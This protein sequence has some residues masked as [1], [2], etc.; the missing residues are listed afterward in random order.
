MTRDLTAN[1]WTSCPGPIGPASVRLF[2][3]PYAGGG[4]SSF[5]GW[6]EHLGDGIVACPVHLPGRERRMR[7]PA[8]RRM[9]PLA[10]AVADALVSHADRPYAFF[11]HSMGAVLAYEAALEL[12]ARGALL[13][14]C[15][16]LSAMR[17]PECPRT[18]EEFHKLP[19]PAM[20][21]RLR[22]FSGTPEEALRHPE[23]MEILLPIIR[24]DFEAVE[25][26]V[27]QDATPLDCP[28]H[29]FAGSQDPE[30]TVDDMEPWSRHTRRT[31]K[32]DVLPGNHFF[33][34]SATHRL[35]DLISRQLQTCMQDHLAVGRSGK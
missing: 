14:S 16:F 35:L 9:A 15:V 22:D 34:H 30:A 26:H 28:I 32:I 8:M 4:A 25:T 20:I 1:P 11:G 21:E 31:F 23:L 12:Q 7:E 18:N 5:R 3:F 29:A 27:Y 19:D 17:A 24:A 13:P 2:C 10:Q 33:L 6:Q